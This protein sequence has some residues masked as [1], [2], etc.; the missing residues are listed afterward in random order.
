LKNSEYLNNLKN[1]KTPTSQHPNS[2]CLLLASIH[3]PTL[4][5]AVRVPVARPP[6]RRVRRRGHQGPNERPGP[7]LPPAG[8]HARPPHRP[9]RPRQ[10]RPRERAPPRARR[11]RP[12]AR[13]GLRAADPRPGGAA[14]HAAHRRPPHRHVQRHLSQGDPAAR[15]RLPRQL[16]LPGGGPRRQHERH[17][18]AAAGVGGGEREALLSHRPAAHGS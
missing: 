17:D 12:H 1:F 6:L 13:H 8:R 10:D 9:A 5:L 3:N 7:G 14:R 16:H 11:G 2:N 15:A 18:H 4:S